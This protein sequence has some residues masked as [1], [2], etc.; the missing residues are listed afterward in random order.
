MVFIPPLKLTIKNVKV[1]F[2]ILMTANSII[3]KL[4]K[5]IKKKN[6]EKNKNFFFLVRPENSIHVIY[7]L[8][9]L[10]SIYA[11]SGI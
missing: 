4:K 1:N 9:L 8:A 6:Q 5:K 7:I 11:L 10:S 2:Q 3:I